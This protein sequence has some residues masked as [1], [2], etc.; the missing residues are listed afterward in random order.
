MPAPVCTYRTTPPVEAITY[1]IGILRKTET[2]SRSGVVCSIFQVIDFLLGFVAS[3]L[4]AGATFKA[5]KEPR[6]S[7]K[8]AAMYLE[9]FLATPEDVRASFQFPEWL[10]PF[11][12][13]MLVKYLKRSSGT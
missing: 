9:N 11:L 7:G 2:A 13:E 3:S 5:M 4:D 1:L 10:I 6:M 12:L 8:Q